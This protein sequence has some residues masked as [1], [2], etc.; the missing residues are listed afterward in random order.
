MNPDAC[1]TAQLLLLPLGVVSCCC[2]LLLL[3]VVV[4]VIPFVAIAA[5]GVTV[6]DNVVIDRHQGSADQSIAE[7]KINR[8]IVTNQQ[9]Q[10]STTAMI[11]NSLLVSG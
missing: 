1:I 7:Q 10:L 9:Q 4:A 11:S 3:I 5:V 8:E 6:S 2:W